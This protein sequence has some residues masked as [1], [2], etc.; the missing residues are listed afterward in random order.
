MFSE[1]NKIYVFCLSMYVCVCSTS[2][3]SLSSTKTK[4]EK[5]SFNSTFLLRKCSLTFSEKCLSCC[6]QKV[7]FNF[8]KHLPKN[9]SLAKHVL[10]PLFTPFNVKKTKTAQN[11]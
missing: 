7:F 9:Y 2:I 1:K 3:G 8:S 6:P 5:K 11:F 10:T 4:T